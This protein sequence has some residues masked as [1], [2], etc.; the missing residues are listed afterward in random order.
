MSIDRASSSMLPAASGRTM[1]SPL[2]SCLIADA[3]VV[4]GSTICRGGVTFRCHD[5]VWNDLGTACR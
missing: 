3:T 4:S 5:G 1:P 2:R